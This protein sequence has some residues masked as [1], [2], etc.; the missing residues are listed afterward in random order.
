MIESMP[1]TDGSPIDRENLLD[2]G[3]IL[4]AVGHA[5]KALLESGDWR[6]SISVVLAELGAAVDVSRAYVFER[7]PG[8]PDDWVVS[9]RFEWTADRVSAQLDNPGLQN[10]SVNEFGEPGWVEELNRGCTVRLLARDVGPATRDLLRGQDILSLAM[11]PIL[12]GGQPWGFI[13]FDDCERERA[14][15]A[16]ELEAM[17]AAASL[18]GSAILRERSGEERR[19]SEQRLSALIENLPGTVYR[20][21][22]RAPWR[23]QQVSERIVD[24]CGVTAREFVDNGRSY[25]ELVCPDDVPMVERVVDDAVT[26]RTLYE[27]EYRLVR[28]GES[29]CWVLERGRAAYDEAGNPLWLDGV[30]FDITD[31]KEA[32]AILK[33]RDEILEAVGFAAERF[34][35]NSDWESSVADVLDRLNLAAGLGSVFLWQEP[36]HQRTGPVGIWADRSTDPMTSERLRQWLHAALADVM[37]H[38]APLGVGEAVHVLVRD[39]P[40]ATRSH[41]EAQGVESGLFVPVFAE[42]V[43]WGAFGFSRRRGLREWSASEVEVMRMAARILGAAIARA[44]AEER[45]RIA[46][47]TLENVTDWAREKAAEAIRAN[48]A[49]SAFL[50]GMS[51]EIRTPLTGVLG[52]LELLQDTPLEPEQRELAT[53]AM[54]SSHALLDLINDILD[55]SKIESGNLELESIEFGLREVV[56][57]AVE[58]LAERAS[59]KGL[60]LAAVIDPRVPGLIRGDPVRLRQILVNL[61][62]NAVKFTERGEVVVRVTLEV[63]DDDSVVLQFSIRDTGIGIS[64]EVREKLFHA[65]TQADMSTTRKYGGTG[66]GLAISLRLVQAMGG[67]IRLDSELGRGS[68]FTFTICL[69]RGEE[70]IPAAPG[71]AWPSLRDLHV[72]V[73]DR[74]APTREAIAAQLAVL[75]PEVVL[76][77]DCAEAIRILDSVQLTGRRID[78]ALVESGVNR[79]DGASIVQVVERHPASTTMSVALLGTLTVR[80]GGHPGDGHARLAK[81]LRLSRLER[82]LQELDGAPT[83]RS[84]V[85]HDEPALQGMVLVVDD[86]PVNRK[87]AVQ[88]VRSLGLSAEAVEDGAAALEAVRQ[89]CWSLVLMDNQMPLMSGLEATRRIRALPGSAGRIPIVAVTASAVSELRA[90]CIEAGM[91]DFLSKPIGR[92]VLRK[93]LAKW[94]P[95]RQSAA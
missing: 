32:E 9:R 12:P 7:H 84:V 82:L 66:L 41:L 86:N 52:T 45:L 26:A 24:L 1:P 56:E 88:M 27:M 17:Q 94:L 16:G 38:I 95:A 20:R 21:E 89:G 8:E 49:K 53:I 75:G 60:A 79:E 10:F 85:E 90:D 73:L 11:V 78:L 92:D 69:A 57:D 70:E 65:F 83:P 43:R 5:A 74:H 91:D 3:V 71:G 6:D 93:V 44:R 19:Q 29:V 30:L 67:F 28:P 64:A 40:E 33:S 35:G 47:A 50:A 87:V 63:Q 46:K 15:S 42:G 31:R 36:E 37:P 25:A 18:L 68:E 61:L 81:P 55:F 59:T 62:G 54:R 72:L 58:L 80:S 51:H 22:F 34:L 48:T 13:G 4:K 77:A 23:M 14:W 39:L 76:A 2:R